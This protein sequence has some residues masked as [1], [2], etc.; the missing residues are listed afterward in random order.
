MVLLSWP[1][2]LWS[3]LSAY[4]R[5]FVVG[6]H[7]NNTCR[8]S[9]LMTV[10]EQRLFQS[11]ILEHDSPRRGRSSWPASIT[12]PAHRP[13]MDDE[14]LG[15]WG[16]T[17]LYWVYSMLRWPTFLHKNEYSNRYFIA[18]LSRKTGLLRML[19]KINE[20]ENIKTYKS[21]HR[22]LKALFYQMFWY[23]KV[24]C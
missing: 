9:K 5:E 13:L 24:L 20:D 11:N 7:S 16:W 14:G 15:W 1:Y 2:N 6:C 17:G 18:T 10:S 4:R 8:T 21:C 3:A 23:Y 22:I 12:Q 19:S